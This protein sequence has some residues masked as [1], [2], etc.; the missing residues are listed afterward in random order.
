MESKQSLYLVFGG[1]VKRIG[2]DSFASP[3]ELEMVGIYDNL[4]KAKEVWKAKSIKYIDDANKRFKLVPLFNILNPSEV[5]LD[6]LK[7]VNKLR[8]RKDYIKLKKTVTLLE[9]IYKLNHSK[10][11]AALIFENKK[12]L[13]IFTEKDII[14]NISHNFKNKLDNPIKNFMTATVKTIGPKK[15]IIQALETLKINGFRHLPVYDRNKKE[16][17]GLISY[18]DFTLSLLDRKI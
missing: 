14:K 16:F 17:Y 10:A 15:S 3:R 1:K 8:I 9:T 6:Y 11:S 5:V 2:I 4:K 18:K 12:L 7:K 13:G